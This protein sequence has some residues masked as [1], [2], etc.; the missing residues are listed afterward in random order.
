LSLNRFE[1]AIF[2]ALHR[3][4]PQIYS[5]L[6]EIVKSDCD[7][8]TRTF[9]KY[10]KGLVNQGIL[11]EKI[12]GQNHEY[13]ISNN[14]EELSSKLSDFLNELNDDAQKPYNNI[15]KFFKKYKNSKKFYKLQHEKQIEIFFHALD[16]VNVILRWHQLLYLITMGS[17][18]TSEIRQQANIL[19][20]KYNTQL[21]ELFNIYKQIDP[22]ISRMIFSNVFND[23]YPRDKRPGDLEII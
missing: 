15:I 20:K 1:N 2:K 18:A 4:G 9:T 21:R 8:S 7:C 16:S 14:K 13:Y 6:Y 11:N 17:F 10:L 22:S 3:N 12:N 5:R 23:L 19:Q